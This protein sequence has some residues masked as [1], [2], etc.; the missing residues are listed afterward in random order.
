MTSSSNTKKLLLYTHRAN[1][2][3]KLC[4][5]IPA[6]YAAELED[7]IYNFCIIYS[8][9]KDVPWSYRISVYNTKLSNI[10]YNLD[11]LNCPSLIIRVMNGSVKIEDI[12][13]MNYTELNPERWSIIIKRNEYT[14]HKRN[15]LATS[16]EHKCRKCGCEESFNYAIQ[17]RSCDEPATVFVICKKCKHRFRM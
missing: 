4:K 15:D 8:N 13:N 16:K 10:C 12:P 3:R 1:G 6:K 14:E 17:T 5:Y 7:S 11:Q 2:Y 9:K